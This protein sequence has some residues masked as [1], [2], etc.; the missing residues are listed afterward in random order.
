MAA[1]RIRF[2]PWLRYSLNVNEIRTDD[3]DQGPAPLG[4]RLRLAAAAAYLGAA[5]LVWASPSARRHPWLARQAAQAVAVWALLGLLLLITVGAAAFLSYAVIF[6]RDWFLA[7][8]LESY[9]LIALRRAA[10]AWGVLALF[11]AAMALAGSRQ[12]LPGIG[13]LAARGTLIR[14]AAATQGALVVLLCLLGALAWHAAALAPARAAE[15]QVFLLFDD[16]DRYPRW[17]FTLPF[18]RI[19]ATAENVWGEQRVEARPLT[20]DALE[21]ALA[22]GR[23]VFLATHGGANGLINDGGWI[24][25]EDVRDLPK[26]QDLAFVYLAGCDSGALAEQWRAALAPAE[27]KTYPRLTATLEHAWWMWTRGPAIVRQLAA[28]PPG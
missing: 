25:P 13:W 5:P 20:R 14:A 21:R 9:V 7:W 19:S 27:V 28:Q 22:N 17:L 23:F 10:L 12:T 11:G 26:A 1:A 15:P 6:H 18:F 8:P 24:R 16:V 2:V 4:W 3:T